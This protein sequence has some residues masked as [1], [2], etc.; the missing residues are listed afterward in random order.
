[1][2]LT[3]AILSL[4]VIENRLK[5]RM[6]QQ[7]P[8]EPLL[9]QPQITLRELIPFTASFLRRPFALNKP[10]AEPRA[11]AAPRSSSTSTRSAA[12]L[13]P[14]RPTILRR[15]SQSPRARN[16]YSPYHRI[17][18]NVSGPAPPPYAPAPN[19]VHHKQA[20]T[21]AS[22]FRT[23]TQMYQIVRGDK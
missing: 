8:L 5:E 13:V 3:Q 1:M 17:A 2:A 9:E 20:A 15:S 21:Y 16:Y 10:S 4:Y 22:A 11:T 18:G 12:Q 19:A 23:S 7:P 6:P 14:T